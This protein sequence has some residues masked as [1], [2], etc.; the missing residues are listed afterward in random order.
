[1]AESILSK[2]LSITWKISI[3]NLWQTISESKQLRA[4]LEIFIDSL[5]LRIS[6]TFVQTIRYYME[7]SIVFFGREYLN[8]SWLSLYCP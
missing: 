7:I 8:L 5:G 4:S 6:K 2:R 3:D 1:M